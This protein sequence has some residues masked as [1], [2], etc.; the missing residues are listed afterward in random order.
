[1][2]IIHITLVKNLGCHQIDLFAA[3]VYHAKI[4]PRKTIKRDI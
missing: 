3:K 4:I 1:M 2:Y